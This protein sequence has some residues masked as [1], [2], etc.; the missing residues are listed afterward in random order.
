[1][2]D[3]AIEHLLFDN[4]EAI[5]R[6]PSALTTSRFQNPRIN[7]RKLAEFCMPFVALCAGFSE[8]L[9][10]SLAQNPELCT[11]QPGPPA[12][13]AVPTRVRHRT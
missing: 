10:E 13:R 2:F 9:R 7:W 11:A 6:Q 5:S 1:M 3:P 12:A 8:S 4:L